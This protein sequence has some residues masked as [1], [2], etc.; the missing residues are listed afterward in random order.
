MAW[1][2]AK[3]LVTLVVP[4]LLWLMPGSKVESFQDFLG[5]AG[6]RSSTLLGGAT[7]PF[8]L[9]FRLHML[10]VFCGV[11]F[12]CLFWRLLTLL[13]GLYMIVFEFLFGG[14]VCEVGTLVFFG[15]TPKGRPL[16]H[17]GGPHKHA[18][19]FGRLEN[20]SPAS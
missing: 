11:L 2:L 8:G 10:F 14:V 7:N 3:W 6:L 19:P 13:V 15:R 16:R 4:H 12:G 5:G 18:H 20:E 1:D 9:F 17:C